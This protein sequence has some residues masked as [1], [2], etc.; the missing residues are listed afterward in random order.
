MNYDDNNIFAKILR[1]EIPCIKVFENE[2]TLAF[3]DIMPQAQGHTLVIP[4][5]PAITIMDLSTS[6]AVD[7]IESV[8][9]ISRA[10]KK[11]MNAEGITLFQLN[12]EAAGQTVPHIHF[13]VMPGS[14][15][16][17]KHH[18]STMADPVELESIA[19]KIRSAL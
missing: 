10:V 11:A 6:A 8:Q 16:G 14:I 7:L 3:M 1:N 5:E 12:G 17:A 15:L 19:Q 4:K 2:T 13:H 9:V 18:A